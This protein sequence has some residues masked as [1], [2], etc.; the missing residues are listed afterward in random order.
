MQGDATSLL[1][2]YASIISLKSEIFLHVVNEDTHQSLH[3]AQC[4][5]C[6]CFLLAQN[7]TIQPK[8]ISGEERCL[9]LAAHVDASNMCIM[10]CF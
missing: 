8:L 2:C 9:A 3:A 5:V 6:W 7:A 10:A 1:N 4:L